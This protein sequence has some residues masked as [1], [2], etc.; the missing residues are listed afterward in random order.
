MLNVVRPS[1]TTWQGMKHVMNMIYYDLLRFGIGS[2]GV[3]PLVKF[4]LNVLQ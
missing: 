4:N 3:R 1:V 2:D